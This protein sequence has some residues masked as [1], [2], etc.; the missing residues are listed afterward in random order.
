[1]RLASRVCKKNWYAILTSELHIS[2]ALVHDGIAHFYLCYF[3]GNHRRNIF[4]RGSIRPVGFFHRLVANYRISR[5]PIRNRSTHPALP[6]RRITLLAALPF[7]AKDTRYRLLTS[8][9]I[10]V[11]TIPLALL[12]NLLVAKG[13]FGDQKI[14]LDMLIHPLPLWAVALCL[15]IFPVSIALSELPTYFAYAL[16]R[17]EAITKRAWL[18][19]GLTSFWLAAQHISLPLLPNFRFIIWRLAMFFP[20][21][22]MLAVVLRWRSRLLP[23]L[24]IIHGLLDFSTALMVLFISLQMM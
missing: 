23:Y 21:A 20:F 4:R 24:V 2:L 19:L 18:A 10:L 8:I 7:R 6:P 22:L 16:P 1:M 13:L 9:A 14:A 17:L 15:T 12:P 5:Q 3:S 11:I